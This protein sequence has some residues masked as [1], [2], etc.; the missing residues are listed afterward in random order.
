MR[1]APRRVKRFQRAHAAA[2][3]YSLLGA[4]PSKRLMPSQ[5]QLILPYIIIATGAGILGGI[6]ASFWIPWS[7]PE[8]NARTQGPKDAKN[9][10]TLLFAALR[11]CVKHGSTLNRIHRASQA[12]NRSQ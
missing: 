7:E 10:E 11:L 6:V 3:T 2:W 1:M 9:E 8:L 5:L 4:S 12:Y